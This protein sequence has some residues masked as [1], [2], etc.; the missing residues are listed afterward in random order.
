MILVLLETIVHGFLI[1]LLL[2][3]SYILAIY[4]LFGHKSSLNSDSQFGLVIMLTLSL[5]VG[6]VYF[7]E[8]IFN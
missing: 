7:L 4:L 8:K 2:I 1:V 6:G 5:F 3:C